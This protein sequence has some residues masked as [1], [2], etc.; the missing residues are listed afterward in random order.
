MQCVYSTLDGT[1]TPRRNSNNRWRTET[2]V[3]RK[4]HDI[5]EEMAMLS[6]FKMEA[7]NSNKQHGNWAQWLRNKFESL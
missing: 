2:A 4:S 5:N 6:A 3:R 7:F 1:T